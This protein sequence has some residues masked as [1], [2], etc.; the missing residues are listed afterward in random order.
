[1]KRS[2][3]KITFNGNNREFWFKAS[4]KE[5]AANWVR[6]IDLHIRESR[7]FK[8]QAIAPKT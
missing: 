5:E 4:S 6:I 1:M 3:F 8:E 7:G 2:Q